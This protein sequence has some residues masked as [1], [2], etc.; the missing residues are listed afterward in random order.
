MER[1]L[2][3]L[4]MLCFLA[5]FGYTLVSFGAGRYLPG[6]FNFTAVACGF[7][8]QTAFLY[9]RGQSIGRCPLTN[10]FE[11]L[12]FLSW[13]LVLVYMVVGSTYRLSLMGAF[14]SPLAFVLQL[15]ALL[16]FT[17]ETSASSVAPANAWGELHG[18]LSV[19]AYGAFALA[20]VTG[21]MF[22]LQQHQLKS[23]KPSSFFYSLP[24]V[25][26]LAVVNRRVLVFGWALLT[27]G[28]GCGLMAGQLPEQVKLA[29]SAAI[30]LGY[31]FIIMARALHRLT[32]GGVAVASACAF[33]ITV[34]SLWGVASLT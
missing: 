12:V 5:S 17:A 25:Q 21:V 33:L 2:F 29:W 9:V 28:F 20:G 7:I 27:V 19:I 18:A 8:F 16:F 11:V 23:G 32:P 15:M 6:R 30:W 14:T 31:A 24:P 26:E 4:S 34:V 22:L 10:L 1:A 13:S 3:I